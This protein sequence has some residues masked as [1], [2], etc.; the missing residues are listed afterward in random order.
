MHSS[1]SILM[2]EAARCTNRAIIPWAIAAR[3]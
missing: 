2:D 3:A 1:S